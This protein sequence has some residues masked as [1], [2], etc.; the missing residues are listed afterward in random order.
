[1]SFT[2][3]ATG[4]V[5]M[6]ARWYQPLPAASPQPV[7]A[8]GQIYGACF[9]GRYIRNDGTQSSQIDE[10]ANAAPADYTLR[11]DYIAAV[12]GLKD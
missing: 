8:Q 9:T 2:D 4:N 5:N 1:V 10:C 6:G 11:N 3:P 12:E 7:Q